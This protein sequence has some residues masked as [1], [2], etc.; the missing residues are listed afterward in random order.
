MA[1][2]SETQGDGNAVR[3][4]YDAESG[5]IYLHHLH[6]YAVWRKAP[7]AIDKAAGWVPLE[8]AII[9]HGFL[10][11]G[12]LEV[13]VYA[14]DQTL[15]GHTLVSAGG[16]IA[17]P[18][19]VADSQKW[20]E[21]VEFIMG[22]RKEYPVPDPSLNSSAAYLFVSG[23][24]P[25]IRW[26]AVTE[27]VM[28]SPIGISDCIKPRSLVNA[29]ADASPDWWDICF[30][31]LEP[32]TAWDEGQPE[33]LD[34]I[35]HR[36]EQASPEATEQLLAVYQQSRAPVEICKTWL[37]AIGKIAASDG[38]ESRATLI[39]TL[40]ER[41]LPPGEARMP[42]ETLLGSAEIR[43]ASKE[44]EVPQE[45][46]SSSV[47]HIQAHRHHYP[48]LAR[49]SDQA[50]AG[51]W[52]QYKEDIGRPDIQLVGETGDRRESFIAFL[53]LVLSEE[54]GS[55]R[56]LIHE[57]REPC[58]KQALTKMGLSDFAEER[59]MYACDMLNL[60]IEESGADAT[61]LV[62]EWRLHANR[63]VELA[64]AWYVLTECCMKCGVTGPVVGTV[65]D[66]AYCSVNGIPLNSQKG[67]PCLGY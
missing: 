11:A 37:I 41:P 21:L 25:L 30:L 60:M 63:M 28:T 49:L 50:L 9:Q 18:G 7:K 39:A 43:G 58:R 67:R 47:A 29:R 20:V 61:D 33:M 66:E 12:F 6:E 24:S 10:P 42:A 48:E 26:V 64:V 14:A 5:K 1:E 54:F 40:E 32:I 52:M 62:S 34:L 23:D 45:A 15:L 3:Y 57:D 2:L 27:G 65:E 51:W 17:Y 44:Q 36:M 16:G 13:P 55:L 8:E 19:V 53:A 22:C 35:K 46:W 56:Y 38:K 31:Q 59:I 4:Q